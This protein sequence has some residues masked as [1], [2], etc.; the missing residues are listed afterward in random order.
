MPRNPGRRML[1]LL[2]LLSIAVCG[3]WAF[4]VH[5][6][7]LANLRLC[8]AMKPGSAREAVLRALGAPT[9]HIMNPAGTRVVLLF[10]SPLFSAHPIRAV[11]N[12]RDDKVVE[13]DCGDGRVRTSDEY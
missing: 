2:A 5:R 8:G 10:T 13:I 7:G 11:V 12:V 4:Q 3:A 9:S 1:L 6:Q